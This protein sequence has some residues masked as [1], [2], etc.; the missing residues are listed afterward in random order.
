VHIPS[1]SPGSIY[2]IKRL[3]TGEVY[4]G[5][6]VC[7]AEQRWAFHLQA[8]NGGA[9]TKL[10]RAIREDG[11]QG[12]EISVLESGIG[13]A[14]VLRQREI[15]WVD[16]FDA[17]GPNGLNSLKAGGL[18]GSKGINTNVDGR[19]FR[20]R[21]DASR[22][23]S[24]ETGLPLHVIETRL[25]KDLPIP[26]KS[27]RHSNHPDAGTEV[28]RKWLAILRRY[29]SNVDAAWVDN[30]DQF[31]ADVGCVDP[32]LHLTRLDNSKP[33]GPSNF[34]WLNVQNKVEKIHG[35]T[36]ECNGI[37]YPSITALAQFHGIGVSTLKDRIRRQGMSVEDAVSLSSK[38]AP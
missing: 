2:I 37:S 35:K 1:K 27:R 14:E 15:Y 21:R 17:L 8:A 36:M 16:Y 38:R 11:E 7:T 28:W 4:I 9:T 31:K 13:D 33:C 26:T 22:T 19:Q 24:N 18:G 12:F 30:Y 29:P 23:I 25:A 32:A 34:V 6:T 10:A 3:S 5:L 20:S